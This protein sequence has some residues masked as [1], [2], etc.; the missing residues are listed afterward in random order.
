M[1]LVKLLVALPFL[2]FFV[3]FLV[4][5]NELVDVWP[6][7]DLK[8]AVSV[9]YFILFCFGYLCGRVSAWS[10]YA[11]LRAMLRKQKKENKVLSK[12]HEKLNHEHER[13]NQQITILQEEVDKGE[14]NRP[15]SLNRKL[16]SWFSKSATEE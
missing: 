11:P 7:P 4:E 6:I 3:L 15:F 8:V 12:E 13:L 16:K 9:V 14:E 2:L 10:A 5:N 1:W